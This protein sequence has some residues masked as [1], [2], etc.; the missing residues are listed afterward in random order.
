MYSTWGD[1]TVTSPYDYEA[2]PCECEPHVRCEHR[3]YHTDPETAVMR[4][5][6]GWV[7]GGCNLILHGSHGNWLAG[8]KETETSCHNKGEDFDHIWCFADDCHVAEASKYKSDAVGLPLTAKP[9]WK[10][11]EE[12]TSGPRYRTFPVITTR[13]STRSQTERVPVLPPPI[14][15][16]T[17]RIVEMLRDM[18]RVG[19]INDELYELELTRLQEEGQREAERMWRRDNGSWAF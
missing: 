8:I 11:R 3:N 5:H 14:P 4:V 1:P 19:A 17:T 18:H 10:V 7:E 12:R 9:G 16:R 2:T 13:P 6:S 15:E